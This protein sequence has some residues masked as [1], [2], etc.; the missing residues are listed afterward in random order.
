MDKDYK[1]SFE[2]GGE[3]RSDKHLS[4]GQ[5]AILDLCLRLALIDNVFKKTSPFILLDDSFSLL[6]ESHMENVKKLLK[7]LA[8]DKQILYFTC[9]RSR[10]I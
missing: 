4:A 5:K 8:S 7:E 1:V 10:A 6:D 2:R 9:H 3:I